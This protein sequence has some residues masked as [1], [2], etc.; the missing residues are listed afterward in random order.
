MP[1]EL[2][3]LESQSDELALLGLMQ[4][5]SPA[6]PIGAFAFSQGLESAFELDWVRDEASLAEWL[7]GVLEDGLTRCE[8]P[9][10]ARLHDAFGQAFGQADMQKV[11]NQLPRGMSGWLLPGKPPSSP[12]KIAGWAPR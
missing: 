1:T 5:V 4:L 7:N 11:V 8:L 10:L 9:V 6:L 3:A 2:T 12:P